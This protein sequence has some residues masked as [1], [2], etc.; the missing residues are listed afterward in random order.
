MQK[1]QQEQQQPY[2]SLGISNIKSKHLWSLQ[3]VNNRLENH[4]DFPT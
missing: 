1:Q 2:S 4:E 3:V